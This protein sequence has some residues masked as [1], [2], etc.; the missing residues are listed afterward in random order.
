MQ[1]LKSWKEVG[2]PK[3]KD[4]TYGLWIPAVNFRFRIFRQRGES[5]QI[6]DYVTEK[7]RSLD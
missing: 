4:K 7:R 5:I 2:M 6:F 1:A 3:V